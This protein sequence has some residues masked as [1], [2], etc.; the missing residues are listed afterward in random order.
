MNPATDMTATLSD[1]E[2]RQEALNTQA[3]YIVSA[4]A[5]SGKTGLIT[6]RVLSLLCRVENPEEI[7]CITFTRKAAAEMKGRIH[8]ALV[9][10]SKSPRPTNQ[11]A[12]QT[13]DLATQALAHNNQM[14]WDLLH[15]PNRLRIKTI[16]SFCNYVNKQFALESALVDLPQQ[17]E[18]PTIYYHMAAREFI[19]QLEHDS[20]TARFLAIIVNHSGNDLSRCEKLFAEM[21]GKRDQWLPHIYNAVD[22]QDYFQHVIE[23]VVEERLYR[24]AEQL[25]PIASQLV[26][27]ADFAGSHAPTDQIELA[28]LQ[29]MTEL[30]PVQLEALPEWKQ[31][32]QLLV[33]KKLEPRKKVTTKE[34]FPAE[35]KTSKQQ[36]L[37]LLTEYQQNSLL[38]S[39]VV[40][41]MHLPA[42]GQDSQQPVINALGQLLP[43]LVAMLKIV[44][45]QH[46][47]CD[48]PEITLGALSAL[49]SNTEQDGV[50]DI[51]LRL[52]YQLKHILVDEFQDTSGSQIKLLESLVSDWQEN[53]G[54]SLFLVGDAMQ[55]L[56]SFRDARVGLFINAQHHPIGNVQCKHLEL[57]SNFRSQKGIVDWVNANFSNAFPDTPDINR[58]AVPYSHSV[59]VK[60]AQ[61]N[62]AVS[63]LGISTKQSNLYDQT[64]A[65][66]IAKLCKQLNQQCPEQSV[67][68]LVRNRSHLRSIVPALKSAQL[69][70]DAVDIDPLADLMPVV[71]L[72]SL[73]RALASPAD[74]VAWLAV[75]RAPFCGLSLTDLLAVCNGSVDDATKSD[76][77]LQRLR[78]WQH[79]NSSFSNLSDQG[80]QI[81]HRVVPLLLQ[82]W[83]NRGRDN[84]RVLIERLWID[85]GGPATL[86]GN[87]DIV[88][89]RTYL[90]L[91][92]NSQIAGVIEDWPQFQKAVEN[93]YAA[94][95]KYS[96]PA[97][98]E[99]A[100][101][102]IQIMTL[103]KAKGLEFDQVIVPGL[104][105]VPRSAENPLLRWQEEIDADNNRSLLLAALGPH[106]EEN[107]AVYR[108]L[109]Y[110][111]GI[112]AQLE[113]ARL[114][115]VAATRA[116]VQLHL[117]AGLKPTKDNW[118]KPSKTSLL[119]PIWQSL[120]AGLDAG[121]ETGNYRIIEIADTQETSE[122]QSEFE[123]EDNHIRQLP[124][125]FQAQPMPEDM[126]RLGVEHQYS[127]QSAPDNMDAR[128][129]HQ[130]TVLHRTLKQIAVEGIDNWP[131]KRR[132]QLSE[133]WTAQLKQ[134]GILAT[135]AELQ[136]LSTALETMLADE[137]GKW[138]L[139]PHTEH[140][141]EQPL[142]YYDRKAGS[143]A[144]VVIDRTFI[145][146][147]TRWI[148]DYKF[149]KPESGESEHSFALR[150]TSI[151]KAKLQQY[152][153]L[154]QQ[155]DNKPVRCALYFPLIALFQEVSSD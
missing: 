71:D 65:E 86:L 153:A 44:F 102:K 110:E 18:F 64:E 81:L 72:M 100:P 28:S 117:F 3:S 34:G 29:G 20:D 127:G 2:A 26:E 120:E 14:G 148:I 101:A 99:T 128:A 132:L 38:Q 126:M 140:Q 27:M 21:L 78:H 82:A 39:T 7:L 43:H 143:T 87:S 53:D 111:Q 151:Y 131:H 146:N 134:L 96:D 47:Q 15:M 125:N 56:Y 129:R 73:T 60:E 35:H 45:Q 149:S 123:S 74:R 16:D 37:Q 1:L 130:G 31:L 107:D 138:I 32:L 122:K 147:G 40:D 68:I 48:Y 94:A 13:W 58:G 104:S 90:D 105:K 137:R 121:L 141:S 19:N 79:D 6:Q 154:Y 106:D 93:L 75:L 59:A 63:F 85:L 118:Q 24:L 114:L 136:S 108:Y 57:N 92:E 62:G 133:G 77:I 4:P 46:N 54:R 12:G 25:A 11:F 76:S 5:G 61:D 139:Q 88:D 113:N 8:K 80:A 98:T 83:E 135:G 112:K 97:N 70:W 119:A 95:S 17:S 91:L 52:D 42:S 9:D 69:H 36:M 30:P 49:N 10:A 67:A 150:Q 115:Y 145:D 89:I 41:V 116:I 23:T 66:E 55:S 33:T 109:K 124:S 50:S 144:G 155:L 22:N 142:A 84:L 51:T 103:F 152:A